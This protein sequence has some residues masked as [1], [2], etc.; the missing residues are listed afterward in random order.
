VSHEADFSK[1]VVSDENLASMLNK[2]RLG[3]EK[4]AKKAGFD[5]KRRKWKEENLFR[6]F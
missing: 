5:C 2:V 6:T 3:R 4:A 1:V